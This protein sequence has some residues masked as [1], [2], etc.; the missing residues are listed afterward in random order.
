LNLNYNGNRR[1]T[2]A[3]RTACI[4]NVKLNII[5]IRTSCQYVGWQRK[6]KLGR[7]KTFDWA[8]CGP[9]AAGWT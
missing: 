3:L 7:T 5:K 8:A 9:G 1:D 6:P 2:M 4:E